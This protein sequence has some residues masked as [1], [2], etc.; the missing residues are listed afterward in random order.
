MS[1]RFSGKHVTLVSGILDDKAYPEML[2]C[3]L[4]HCRRA[5]LTR[6]TI[7]RATPPE[8]LRNVAAE[9]IPDVTVIPDAASAL[10]HALA[11]SSPDH[12]IIV[13][14]SLYLAGEIKEA[15][16]KGKVK[17]PSFRA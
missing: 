4:P 3:L 9:I 5:I 8:A 10:N 2:R 17:L 6:P 14:G 7:D 16:E 13:A 1:E 11:T 12:V 15:I